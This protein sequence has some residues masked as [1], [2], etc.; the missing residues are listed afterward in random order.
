MQEVKRQWWKT[1]SEMSSL[2]TI[3]DV[4]DASSFPARLRR[5]TDTNKVKEAARNLRKIERREY[6]DVVNHMNRN[7]EKLERL[8]FLQSKIKENSERTIKLMD[9]YGEDV[10]IFS[11]IL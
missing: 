11:V 4:W 10:S 9:E 8:C 7:M 5:L 1:S 6:D 3:T 2:S